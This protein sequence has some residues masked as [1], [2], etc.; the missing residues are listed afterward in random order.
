MCKKKLTQEKVLEAA[1]KI[2]SEKGFHGSTT[3]EIAEEAGVA[4]G[5]IFK[6]FKTK[7]DLLVNTIVPIISRTAEMLLHG[8]KENNLEE[9]INKIFI[10]RSR[11]VKRAF[12]ILKII[13]LEGE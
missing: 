11:F 7:K 6:Y 10:D 3:K 8:G 2:F 5:T 12:P 13:L 4:E 9:L 1:E